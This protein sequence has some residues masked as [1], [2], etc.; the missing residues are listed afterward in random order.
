MFTVDDKLDNLINDEKDNNV[1]LTESSECSEQ[2]AEVLSE[3]TTTEEETTEEETTEEE[4]TEDVTTEEVTTEETT[5]DE[6]EKV[7]EEDTVS[8]ETDSEAE[9][10]EVLGQGL[11][12]Y[13]DKTLFEGEEKKNSFKEKLGKVVKIVVLSLL[14]LVV[15][16][17]IGIS[18]WFM[19]HY[20]D[21]T[22][23]NDTDISFKSTEYAKDVIQNYLDNY[24][25]TIHMRDNKEYVIKPDMIDL[26]ITSNLSE[27]DIK[28][29]QNG[30]LWP[31]YI[32]NNN[33]YTLTYTVSYN[34]NK[35]REV[36]MQYDCLNTALMEN[37]LN[38]YV[39][40]KDKT[41]VVIPETEG[42]V[43][44][45]DLFLN[46]IKAALDKGETEIDLTSADCYRKAFIR[47]DSDIIQ[48]Q[49]DAMIK[50]SKMV[51]HYSIDEITF[52]LDAETFVDWM[53]YQNGDWHF[54]TPSIRKYVEDMANKYNTV[55]TVRRF[56]TY[57]GKY[58]DE[59]GEDYG[60]LLDVE[61]EIV[62]LNKL[63]EQGYSTYRTPSFLQMGA[64]YNEVNDIGDS[65]VEVDLTNQHVY[66]IIDGKLAVE[67]DCVTGCKNNGNSTPDGL[68]MLSHKKSPAILVGEDYRTKVTYWMPFNRGIGLHDATW[69]GRFGGDIY[70]YDGSHGCVNLPYSVAAE[71]YQLIYPGIPI[72]CYY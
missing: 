49:M 70:V 12:V 44:D 10:S 23:I 34:E 19:F 16:A 52:E 17:Y 2:A 22:T 28:H 9:V 47:V 45:Y 57:T 11:D 46:E 53:Y 8:D 14:G 20:N 35:L 38:A 15:T 71:I 7:V 5:N 40:I 65:Y 60:W 68:Y 56:K 50:Y 18:V 33:N 24:K 30:L 6:P 48:E 43:L 37:P 67:S 51:I 69:R 1:E 13:V 39:T 41:A 29:E 64:A 55:G 26:V 32:N 42:S 61:T 27:M 21:K 4:T 36:I 54:K 63:L 25:L 58:V 59:L 62:A 3:E 66:M 31:F 72:I